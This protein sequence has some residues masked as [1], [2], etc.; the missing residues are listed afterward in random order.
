MGTSGV[1]KTNKKDGTT[2]FRAS[3]TYKEKH[4]SLGSFLTEEA[5]GAAYC[6]AREY[7]DGEQENLPEDY[8]KVISVRCK[9]DGSAN[10]NKEKEFIKYDKWI[11]EFN[12]KTGLAEKYGMK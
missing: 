3:I 7:L 5:A 12:Q 4:I 10:R 6:F 9:K 1:F 11:M 2:Y 8:E